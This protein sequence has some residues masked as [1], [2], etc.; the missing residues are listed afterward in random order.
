MLSK[1]AAGLLSVQVTSSPRE[2]PPERVDLGDS[3]W[4][5]MSGAPVVAAD[6]LLGV[7]TEH[8]PREG[9]RRSRPSP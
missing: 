6:R 1:L 7:V 4:S 3:E 5:G 2:L 8:A 9:S